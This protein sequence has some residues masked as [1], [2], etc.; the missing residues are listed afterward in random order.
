MISGNTGDGVELTGTGT[1]SNVVLGNLIGTN[2]AGTAAIANGQDGVEIDTGA[3]GNIIGGTTALARNIISGNTAYGVG[4]D[5]PA[6]D[7]VVEGDYIGTN[8]TGDVVLANTIGVYIHSSD[9]TIGGTAAG[10]GNV[11]AGNV[12]APLYDR[13]QVLIRN[14]GSTDNLVE[15]NLIG[16]GA[17]GLPFSGAVNVGV[18]LDTGATGNTIGGTTA[19]ARNVILGQSGWRRSG[20]RRG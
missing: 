13:A 14:N 20:W 6:T 17:N 15:G 10:A 12:D 8:V 18:W 5:T 2:A 9:N 16:L 4:I 7:N 11:I 3:S 1:A 19:A